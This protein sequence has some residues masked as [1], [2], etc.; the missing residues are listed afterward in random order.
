LTLATGVIRYGQGEDFE[1]AEG[2]PETSAG[3]ENNEA[4]HDQKD[5]KKVFP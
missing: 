3:K 5:A 2:H 4:G 1:K